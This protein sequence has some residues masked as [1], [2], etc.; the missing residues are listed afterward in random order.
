MVW[1]DSSSFN[2]WTQRKRI[3]CNSN[4]PVKLPRQP[5][6]HAGVTLWGALGRCLNK[7]VFKTSD[8]TNQEDYRDF[9]TQVANEVKDEFKG[10]EI[11]LCLDN[12][13]A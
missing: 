1:M 13:S 11:L 3:W 10:R 6:R 8:S 12:H 4:D 2:A 7:A 9:I 5:K